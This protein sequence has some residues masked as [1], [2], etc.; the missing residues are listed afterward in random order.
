MLSHDCGTSGRHETW[1]SPQS[2]PLAFPPHLKFE[3]GCL[4]AGTLRRFLFS[5]FFVLGEMGLLRA[6]PF[7]SFLQHVMRVWQ[8][9]MLYETYELPSLY[10]HIMTSDTLFLFCLDYPRF[11]GNYAYDFT[12]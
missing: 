2:Q 1:T 11:I 9:R 8:L 7:P 12:T 10:H 5:L 4:P 3:H 6:P